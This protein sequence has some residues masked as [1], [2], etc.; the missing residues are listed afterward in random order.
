MSV[1]GGDFS[2]NSL[3]AF[4]N[5]R[6]AGSIGS[7]ATLRLNIGRALST[8]N[9]VFAGIS[10]RNDGT[11][12]GTIGSDATVNLSAGSISV[13]GFFQ[14]FVTTNGGGSIQGDATNRVASG[15]DLTA[16]QGILVTIEDTIFGGTGNF[17]GGHIGGNAIVTLGGQKHHHPF[18]EFRKLPELT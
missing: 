5:D 2:A 9:D 17:T 6:H 3:T 11:G 8:T 7:S 15:G 14:T 18:Y 4:I 1:T 16:Q 13:G 10:M 12:G